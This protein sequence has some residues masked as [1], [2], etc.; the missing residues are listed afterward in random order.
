M[1]LDLRP[2]GGPLGPAPA[3]CSRFSHIDLCFLIGP[4][5]EPPRQ[6]PAA[7]ACA[8]RGRGSLLRLRRRAHHIAL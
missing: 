2:F 1:G 5:C 8:G 7:S 4:S 6:L 3:L